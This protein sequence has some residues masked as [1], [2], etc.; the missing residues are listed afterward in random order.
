MSSNGDISKCSHQI[1]CEK[2]RLLIT[3]QNVSISEN[4]KKKLF[5][6][7]N[8]VFVPQMKKMSV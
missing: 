2:L 6:L 8:Q 5:L 1:Q 7:K 4:N 3:F